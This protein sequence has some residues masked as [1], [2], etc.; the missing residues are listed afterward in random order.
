M[1]TRVKLSIPILVASLAL[2]SACQPLSHQESATASSD[3]ATPVNAEQS[4]ESGI[5]NTVYVTAT[6]TDDTEGDA[7][8]FDGVLNVRNGCLYMNDTLIAIHNPNL[9]WQQNPF[10]LRNKSDNQEYRIGDKV[11]VSGNAILY[12]KLGSTSYKWRNPVKPE[13]QSEYVWF[14]GSIDHI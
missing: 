13:C 14:V 1:V 2:V 8:G 12:S 4:G 11:A 6:D 9:E 10:I 7:A 3:G 5:E